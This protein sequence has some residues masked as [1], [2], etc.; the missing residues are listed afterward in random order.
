MDEVNT[1]SGLKFP[2]WMKYYCKYVLP[3]IIVGVL[4]ISILNYFI[5][6]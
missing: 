4:I 3:L 2:K 1:G 5:R 6:F